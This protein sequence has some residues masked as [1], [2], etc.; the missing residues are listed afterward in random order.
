MKKIFCLTVLSIC[1]LGLMGQVPQKLSYQAVVRDSHNAL[2]TNESATVKVN[3][4]DAAGE[5]TWYS[6]SHNVTTNAN[7]LISLMIG[8]GTNV[9]GQMKDVKWQ[10]A[11]IKTT[12][13]VGGESI[14][15]TTLVTA[16][17]YA[18]YADSAKTVDSKLISEQ[19]HQIVD[20]SIRNLNVRI[21]LVNQRLDSLGKKF[22]DTLK[23]YATQKALQD[24]AAAIRADIAAAQVNADWE[25]TEG[26][27]MILH[28]PDLGEYAKTTDIPTI[29][30]KVSV[31]ENDAHYITAD[32]IPAQVKSDWNATSGAAE[33]L[34]KPDLSVY[35]KITDIP[36]VPT[37]VSELTNDVPYI[38]KHQ[39]DSLIQE[40]EKMKQ[41]L[42]SVISE[43]GGGGGDD[44]GCGTVTDASSNT[45]HTVIIGN[46]CWMK[47]NLRTTKYSSG[48]DIATT[49][50]YYPDNTESNKDTYGLLYNWTAVM[51]GSA[52]SSTNPSGVQGICPNDWHLPSEAEWAQLTTYVKSQGLYH[53]ND[54]SEYIAKAL[55]AN[56]TKWNSST[57]PCAVGNPNSDNNGTGFS[58]L[59]AGYYNNSYPEFGEVAYFWSATQSSTDKASILYLKA[60]RADVSTSSTFKSYGFPVR[61]VKNN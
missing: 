1:V 46:Q 55:A 20:P 50:W 59:P 61:C 2:V 24:T 12:I 8:E 11:A 56:T 34:N 52:S 53:C 29:P 45:Y 28:K 7:G 10:N 25:A 49:S 36:T 16:I 32:D 18:S 54:N 13:E 57:N 4:G 23:I 51:N 3:I 40:F 27:A 60:D 30:T 6:E 47:E 14:E 41:R 26:P 42:D 43:M 37:K 9:S 5:T 33:I 48:T 39:F 38:T 31:F 44:P 35:A 58:A 21:S 15:N 17:P 19:V 22:T